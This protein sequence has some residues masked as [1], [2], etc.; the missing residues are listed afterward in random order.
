MQDL[1]KKLFNK[2]KLNKYT[3]I[4]AYKHNC[5]IRINNLFASTFFQPAKACKNIRI[6]IQ[7]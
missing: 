7:I 4:E 3:S 1:R 5:F 6:N 2:F